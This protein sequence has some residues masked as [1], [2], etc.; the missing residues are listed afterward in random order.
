MVVK[1]LNGS[2]GFFNSRL[3]LNDVVLVIND[4]ELVFVVDLFIGIPHVSS[5]MLGQLQLVR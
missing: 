1:N 3:R 4:I 2:G 5:S